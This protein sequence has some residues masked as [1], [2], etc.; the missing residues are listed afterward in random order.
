MNNY[1]L[2]FILITF[3][4]IFNLFLLKNKILLDQIESSKH[5]KFLVSESV[6][7]SGGIFIFVALVVF[8]KDLSYLDKLLLSA[9]FFLGLLSDMQRLKSPIIRLFLQ[10]LLILIILIFNK[11][12]ISQTRLH[13]LD[14]LIENFFL[15]KFFFTLLCLLILMNGVN[16]IDGVNGLSTGYFIVILLNILFLTSNFDFKPNEDLIIIFIFLIVFYIFNVFSKSFLG[17]G[18]C[19]LLSIYFGLYLISFFNTYQ[20]L[21]SP[22]YICLLLWYPAF[23]NLFSILRRKFFKRSF[24]TY[25][26]NEHLHHFL[27]KI[28]NK[29]INK[30][31]VSNS[32]CGI[33]INFINFLFIFLGSHFPNNTKILILL[34]ILLI[35]IY[36]FIYF[37]LKKSDFKQNNKLDPGK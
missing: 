2:F 34:I 6:P 18:G 17:D 22:Y 9:I 10:S 36:L 14:F 33:I 20:Y 25:A 28:L 26:D 7:L 3:F 4:Y 24:T 8:V 5:K 35:C 12:Y 32:L 31:K 29:K 23:E 30:I 15:I 37:I 11:N 1:Y 27:F 16:F 21:I 19:Y 13:Y